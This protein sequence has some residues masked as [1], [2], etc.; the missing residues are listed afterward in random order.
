MNFWST[1]EHSLQ[2]KYKGN[3][4][5]H[6]KDKLLK[7][8]QAIVTLDSEMS[9]VRKEILDAQHYYQHKTTV[10][11]N[12]LANIENLYKVANK[13]EVLKIQDEFLAIYKEDNI[14]KIERFGQELD[15]VAESYRA[16]RII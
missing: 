13:R 5:E 6:V 4:P 8:A 2:Y 1:V 10:V 14:E 7:S 9:V 12:I 11:S 16:Q 15:I 3:M